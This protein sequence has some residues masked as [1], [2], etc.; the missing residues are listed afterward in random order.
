MTRF[1]TKTGDDGY[2]SLLGEGRA[3]KYD[4]RIETVGTIDEANAAIALARS[5]SISP[6]TSQI[7]LEVQRD[8][9][10]LMSEVAA[11]LENAHR[12]RLITVERVQWL[13]TQID[14]ISAKVI[15]PHEFILPGDSTPGAALDLA[16]TVIRRA[17][18]HIARL[19]HSKKID[20]RE[21][22][23]YMNRLSSLCFLLELFENQV[24][25]SVQT[26]LA[27]K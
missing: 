9:Y 18:R 21:I 27:K 15:I 5:L 16:R 19:L 20:N 17:E 6:E 10:H 12:F 8:L 24:S 11:T 2:T 25:G 4:R 22:L 1:Y 23:H 13:E 7:L 14:T 3:P 26:T